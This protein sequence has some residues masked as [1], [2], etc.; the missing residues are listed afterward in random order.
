[1]PDKLQ[2][3][4]PD[5]LKLFEIAGVYGLLHYLH[6]EFGALLGDVLK[7]ATRNY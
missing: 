3:Y 2:T 5:R 6:C 7:I 4:F 1:M